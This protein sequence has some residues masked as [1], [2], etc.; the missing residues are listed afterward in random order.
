M[1]INGYQRHD[2][3][4]EVRACPIQLVSTEPQT[5][6]RSV[7]PVDK[8]RK[9]AQTWQCSD[10]LLIHAALSA[11]KYQRYSRALTMLDELVARKPHSAEYHNN[12]GLVYFWSGHYQ[13]ALADCNRAIQL[14]PDLDRAYNNRGNCQA[15]LGQWTQALADYEK[16]V[17]LNPFNVR[18]RINLG[19]TLRDLG[20]YDEALEALEE[21][22]MFRQMTDHIYGER[23]RTYHLRG[24][25][26]CAI[27]DY[28]RALDEIDQ[29]APSSQND[30]LKQRIVDWR[31]ELIPNQ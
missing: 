3:Q 25:W 30:S 11:A 6:L 23:G 1:D 9:S 5:R 19:I 31:S 4:P 22:L 20:C 14:N 24:D 16:A 29:L 13:E 7:P 8:G 21:A 2:I 17:D 15:A 26:N 27:A 28:Q 12:R 18:A 10:Q